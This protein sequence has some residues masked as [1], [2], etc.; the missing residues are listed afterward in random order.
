MSVRINR[1]V[2][3]TKIKQVKKYLKQ[4]HSQRQVARIVQLSQYVV[5]HINRGTYDT[6][7]QLHNHR[8]ENGIFVHGRAFI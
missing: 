5:W 8:Q 7:E 4:G 3:N 2:T 6:T 1:K